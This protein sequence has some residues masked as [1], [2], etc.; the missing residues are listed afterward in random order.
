MVSSSAA[1]TGRWLAVADGG[2]YPEHLR[3]WLRGVEQPG[4][5]INQFDCGYPIPCPALHP[6]SGPDLGTYHLLDGVDLSEPFEPGEVTLG[7][8]LPVIVSEP[9]TLGLDGHFHYEVRAEDPDGDRPLRYR[10]VRAPEG[11]IRVGSEAAIEWRPDASQ[12]GRHEV[13][14][15]VEDTEGGATR[16]RF[17]VHVAWPGSMPA[18]PAP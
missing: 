14:V 12:A 18:S 10:L 11:M 13:E 4:S 16:Q 15:V 9:P 7:N 3:Y 5:P 2:G 6:Y 17:E 8:A 1:E